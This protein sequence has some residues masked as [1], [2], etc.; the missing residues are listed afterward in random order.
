MLNKGMK[1]AMPNRIKALL[2]KNG[3]FNNIGI[4]N[5]INTPLANM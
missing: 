3:R 2:E 5:R 4:P 1:T